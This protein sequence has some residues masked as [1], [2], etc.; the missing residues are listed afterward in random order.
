MSFRTIAYFPDIELKMQP[1]L[2]FRKTPAQLD[3]VRR[4]MKGV[5]KPF[6]FFKVK[7]K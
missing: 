4:A 1:S 2:S 6:S 3:N 5:K 7:E